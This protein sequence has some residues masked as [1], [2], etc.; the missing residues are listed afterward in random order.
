MGI[1][2]TQP[3]FVEIWRLWRHCC[4][5]EGWY[6]VLVAP[7]VTCACLFDIYSSTGCDFIRVDIGFVPVNDVWSAEYAQLGVFQFDDHEIDRNR[8]KRTFNDGCQ[9]YSRNFSDI[10][11]HTD[12]SWYLSRIMA[13]VSGIASLVALATVW[14]LIVTPL[15]AS[16]FWP[17]VL[18]PAVVL[19]MLAGVANFIFFDTH[20]CTEPL[21]FVDE[22]S[23]PLAAQS[24]DIGASSVSAMASVAGYFVCT[25]L[26]CFR[27][28]KRRVL[29][30]AFGLYLEEQDSAVKHY[31]RT[32]LICD[33]PER[34]VNESNDTIA[35]LSDGECGLGIT[36]KESL[37]TQDSQR[38]MKVKNTNNTQIPK[39]NHHARSAPF[40]GEKRSLSFLSQTTPEVKPQDSSMPEWNN[41]GRPIVVT[42][43]DSDGKGRD[44]S[45]SD[46][47][48][49][50]SSSKSTG[51]R[52]LPT[53]HT[54]IGTKRPNTKGNISVNKNNFSR[55]DHESVGSRM[56]KPSI[57]SFANTQASD[58]VSS[59]GTQSYP[60]APSAKNAPSV[61]AIPKRN[62][63][64]YSSV[65]K[66]VWHQGR[67][68]EDYNV[69]F[70]N[71]QYNQPPGSGSRLD[72]KRDTLEHLPPLEEMAATRSL[73][74]HG[75]LIN[76]CVRDL[77]KSFGDTGSRTI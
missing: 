7:L 34:H 18:L 29:D 30:P 67:F 39:H 37:V 33:G 15:P 61:V 2:K 6:P 75:D 41:Y 74:D 70:S 66:K 60:I 72:A 54:G 13:Y 42:I 3:G 43:D 38:T 44:R 5:R 76:Q 35:V 49:A 23:P 59:L 11:I 40:H 68:R 50:Q 48:I 14:L 56:S 65:G 17:G 58:D 31:S 9:T 8:W 69:V 4:C 16:F 73:E 77:H 1:V 71:D 47:S 52:N 10:F 25:L 19:A 32:T 36:N 12:Q 21:Y 62:R 28:P 22:S 20:I 24:C 51:Y 46:E 64:A 26:I 53:R 45:C 55:S 27:G 57:L 63:N